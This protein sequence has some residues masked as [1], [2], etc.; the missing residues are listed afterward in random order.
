M[1]RNPMKNTT[2]SVSL[3]SLPVL[4]LLTIVGMACAFLPG[5]AKN[6]TQELFDCR[7]AALEPLVG[8]LGFDAA[9]LL[10]DVYAG[11][12][13]LGAVVR[14]ARATE[15]QVDALNLALAACEGAAEVP[16][17]APGEVTN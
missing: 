17:A 7:A 16:S 2:Q 5:G 1:V 12:A 8:Q 3:I 15:A 6:P 4:A 9:D 10:R 13:S 11:K 14:A